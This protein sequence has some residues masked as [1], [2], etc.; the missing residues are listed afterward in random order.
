[1]K[2]SYGTRLYLGCL[3]VP[4]ITYETCGRLSEDPD[5][6]VLGVGRS[7]MKLDDLGLYLNCLIV[8]GTVY[9]PC[10]ELSAT[11]D[12][13]TYGARWSARGLDGLRL[14]VVCPSILIVDLS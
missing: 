4:G 1:V 8:F 9:V 14:Y 13:S 7:A 5:G 10:G 2:G 3:V 12:S 6:P 11:S